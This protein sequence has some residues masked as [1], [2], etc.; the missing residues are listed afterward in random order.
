VRR[1]LPLLLSALAISVVAAPLVAQASDPFLQVLTGE[2]LD[3]APAQKYA[4]LTREEAIAALKARGA[5]FDEVPAEQATGVVAPIRLT[6]R[7]NGVFIHGTQSEQARARSPFEILDA[8]LALTLH[9][10]AGILARHGVDE[11]VHFS[12]FRPGLAGYSTLRPARPPGAKLLPA[13]NK[14]APA[15]AAPRAPRPAAPHAP[16]APA[17]GAQRPHATAA[18][19]PPAR[20]HAPAAPAP[21]PAAPPVASAAPAAGAPALHPPTPSAGQTTSRHPAGLAIDVGA[22]KKKDGTTL[23]IARHFAGKIGQQTC[24]EKVAEP[25]TAEARELRAIVCEAAEAR[26]FTFVLS[27]NFNRAHH[28]HLHMEIKAGAPWMLVH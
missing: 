4:R 25:A 3:A 7:L 17:H 2:E 28:D 6:S 12:M 18:K 27:P 11:I 20:R 26:V 22:F 23:D 1:Y 8:R 21:A 5:I 16:H 19:A 15:K 13:G 10:F 9:D 14:K 24:G